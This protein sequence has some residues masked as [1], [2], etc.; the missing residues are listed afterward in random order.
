[1]NVGDK[2]VYIGNNSDHHTSNNYY[3]IVEVEYALWDEE[4]RGDTYVYY[5]NDIGGTEWLKIRQF[6]EAGFITLK[7]YRKYKIQKLNE[8][9]N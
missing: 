1:M 7:N 4:K 3:T 2:I 9:N 5:Y 6:E 8:V